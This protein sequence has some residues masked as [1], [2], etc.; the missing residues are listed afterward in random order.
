MPHLQDAGRSGSPFMPG[1]RYGARIRFAP[2]DDDGVSGTFEPIVYKV[3]EDATPAAPERDRDRIEID[4]DDPDRDTRRARSDVERG[5]R[6]QRDDDIEVIAEGETPAPKPAGQQGDEDDDGPVPPGVQKRIDKAIRKQREAE[7]AAQEAATRAEH[8]ERAYR[9]ANGRFQQAD[10]V[11][12]DTYKRNVEGDLARLERDYKEAYEAGDS[13]KL[14]KVQRELASAQSKAD[15]IAAEERR[16]PRPGQP[17]QPQLQGQQPQARQ[18]ARFEPATLKWVDSNS[19]WFNGESEDHRVL[20]ASAYALDAVLKNEGRD[21]NTPEFWQELDRRLDAKFPHLRQGRAGQQ[22]G[23]AGQH[24]GNG[25]PVA[26][27]SRGSPG[28]RQRVVLS[29]SEMKIARDLGV[30]PQDYA[31]EKLKMESGHASYN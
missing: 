17:A 19:D 5:D 10:T 9:E 13:D 27:P 23:Q 29:Q 18:P 11:A 24:R 8:A 15:W 6:R 16:R 3:G 25:S 12:F 4:L 7:R 20:T 1:D 14:W 2:P 26:G 22:A 28:G 31:R 21:P 30:T